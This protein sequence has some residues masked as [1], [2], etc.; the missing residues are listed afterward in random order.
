MIR[1]AGRLAVW[2]VR[3]E[4]GIWR[5]LALWVS[6]RVPGRRPE[7]Q[8][9]PYAREVTPILLAFIWGSM[10]EI[11]L[12]HLLL[13]WET[14]RLIALTFGIW[15]LLWMAGLL[16]SMRVHQH[17]VGPSGLR[18]RSGTTL[19]LRIPW[20]AIERI[21]VQRGRAPKEPEPGVAYIDQMSQTRVT[22]HLRRPVSFKGREVREVRVYAD[23]PQALVTAALAQIDGDARVDRSRTTS[24][25]PSAS[26]S[27]PLN[28]PI[29]DP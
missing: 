23:D 12:V 26:N 14:V 17:L 21:S 3:L 16:A 6:R 24:V 29:A 20:D 10:L 25:R 7:V 13:P 18:V 19:D 5:S 22:V 9:F 4:I 27:R 15:G 11:V 8:A 28:V 2:L 1:R